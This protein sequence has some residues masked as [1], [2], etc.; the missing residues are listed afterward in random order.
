M[1]GIADSSRSRL[2]SAIPS[3]SRSLRSS[4]PG[5]P[6]PPPGR[7]HRATVG[8]RRDPK[9]MLAQI[10][11]DRLPNQGSSST[12]RNATGTRRGVMWPIHDR[13]NV[14]HACEFSHASSPLVTDV[15]CRAV[16]QYHTRNL[17]TMNMKH[18]RHSRHRRRP[19][20][21]RSLGRL[22]AAAGYAVRTAA[23]GL[24]D[25]RPCNPHPSLVV[26]DI[27]MPYQRGASSRN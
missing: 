18:A 26:T 10:V 16:W 5:R 20:H 6:R 13:L 7:L 21:A 23:D 22:A 27:H 19:D 25:S 2:A 4:T 11:A 3:S 14:R 9:V 12:A 1:I 15:T 17:H 24:P 8:N